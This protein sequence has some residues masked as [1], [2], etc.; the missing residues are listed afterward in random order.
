[1]L[2]QFTVRFET[3]GLA[4]TRSVHSSAWDR[5]LSDQVLGAI[6]AELASFYPAGYNLSGPLEWPPTPP[7]LEAPWPS[8]QKR[9][10][11]PSGARLELEYTVETDQ[12]GVAVTQRVVSG[13]DPGESGKRILGAI[14]GVLGTSASSAPPTNGD[15]NR[16]RLHK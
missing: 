16:V 13:P 7:G 9:I 14:L 2:M 1:M 11:A 15:P 6:L 8:R 5:Q 3:A 10:L 12:S 4:V